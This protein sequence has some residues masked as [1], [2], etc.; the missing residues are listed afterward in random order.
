MKITY[1]I[2]VAPAIVMAFLIAFAAVAFYSMASEKRA[3]DDLFNDNLKN[4]E[5]VAEHRHTLADN[6]SAV[7][8]LITWI[9]TYDEKAVQV[10]TRQIVGSIDT[11]S[12]W[13]D[14]QAKAN[15]G[16][17]QQALVE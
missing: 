4:F 1:R 17:E 9:K 13:L 5:Q 15:A 10:R 6:H 3:L 16:E 11:V 12:G 14:E 7:Y 8:R 2:L